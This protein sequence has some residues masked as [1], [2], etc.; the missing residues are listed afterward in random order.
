M[1][2]F[3][4]ENRYAIIKME[5]LNIVSTGVVYAELWLGFMPFYIALTQLAAT[6]SALCKFYN[7]ETKI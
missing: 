5:F 7:G 6:V 4:F 1:Q 2:A 3:S